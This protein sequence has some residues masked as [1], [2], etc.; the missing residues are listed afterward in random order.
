MKEFKLLM[1]YKTNIFLFSIYCINYKQYLFQS[2]N[3]TIVK[4][5]FLFLN[6]LK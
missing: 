3:S 4:Q 5:L 2:S 6:V 1:L